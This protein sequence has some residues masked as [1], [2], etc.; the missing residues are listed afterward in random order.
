MIIFMIISIELNL[1]S[2][3]IDQNI[4]YNWILSKFNKHMFYDSLYDN[5]IRIESHK[6]RHDIFQN[7][8]V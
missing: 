2:N 3:V 8:S 6:K 5:L 4:F 1:R 7:N